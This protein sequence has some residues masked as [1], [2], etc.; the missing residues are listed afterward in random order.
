MRPWCPPGLCTSHQ[1]TL[2]TDLGLLGSLLYRICHA[3]GRCRMITRIAL[4]ATLGYLLD[5]LGHP[6]DSWQ[7]W[8]VLGLFWA[9]ERVVHLEINAEINRILKELTDN[10]HIK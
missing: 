5:Y 4:Y 10:G 3:V 6:W 2:Y 7:F 1:R 8:A 9:A